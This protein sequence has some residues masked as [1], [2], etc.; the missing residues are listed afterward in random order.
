MLPAQPVEATPSA[1]NRFSRGG[2]YGASETREAFRE[3][4][5]NQA[6]NDMA[7]IP[8]YYPSWILGKGWTLG[9]REAVPRGVPEAI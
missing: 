5:S 7:I 3:P 4:P 1:I 2:V 9:P 6:L 8:E